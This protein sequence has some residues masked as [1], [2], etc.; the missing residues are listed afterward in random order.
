MEQNREGLERPYLEI[1]GG[2]IQINPEDDETNTTRGIDTSDGPNAAGGSLDATKGTYIHI[3]GGS[4]KVNAP[5]DG[6]NPSGDLYLGGGTV[7]AKD[8]AGGGS[9]VSDHNGTG[10]I[11]GRT[12][13]VAGNTGMFQTFSESSSQ[14]MLMVYFGKVQDAGTTISVKDGLGNQLAEAGVSK[15]FEALPFNSSEL[16]SG[17]TYCIGAGEQDI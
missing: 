13:L 6:I 1:I 8:P 11:P 16:K 4:V 3:I 15:P 12:I 14:P 9:D 5:G 17:K 10:T 2:T 7:L